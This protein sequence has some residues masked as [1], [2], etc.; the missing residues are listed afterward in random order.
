M[1]TVTL[2]VNGKVIG[3]F[4]IVNDGTGDQYRANY[5][6]RGWHVRQSGVREH[7][8]GKL[9]RFDRDAGARLL[10]AICLSNSIDGASQ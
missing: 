4:K 6:V 9:R 5:D 1:L 3:K 2:E 7:H 8:A 10:A